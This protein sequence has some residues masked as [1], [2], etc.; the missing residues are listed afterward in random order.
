[1]KLR[2]MLYRVQSECLKA[3]PR[4]DRHRCEFS[5]SGERTKQDDWTVGLGYHHGKAIRAQ[6]NYVWKK[7]NE[8]YE[9]ALDGSVLLTNVQ[10]AF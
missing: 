1:M 8:E 7:T 10:F 5:E 2:E 3:R 6:V 4:F 9:T